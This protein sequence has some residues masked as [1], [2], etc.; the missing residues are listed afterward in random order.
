ME[1]RKDPVT[2]SWMLVGDDEGAFWQEPA[3]PCEW[4]S[5][6]ALSSGRPI[7]VSPGGEVKVYPHPHPL[8]RIEGTESS[9]AEGL[10]D[11]MRTVGAHEVVLESA[12]H[13]RQVSLA[14]DREAAEVLSTFAARIIDLKKD[15]RFRYVTVVKNRGRLA[16]EEFSHA[17]SQITATPFIPRRLVYELRAARAHFQAKERCVFCDIVQQEEA[18]GTRVVE[19]TANYLALCPFA[20]RVPYELWILPRYHAASYEQ[21]IAGRSGDVQELAG[22]VRRALARVQHVAEAYHTVLH[23]SP[24]TSTQR[25]V[26]VQWGTLPDDYHWHI[27]ILPIAE[28][29]TRSYSI[30]EVYYSA[31]SP[32]RAAAALRRV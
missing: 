22:V 19:A 23:T 11:R 29:R 2:Q 10:Y 18:I 14:T 28:K 17:H 15:Q 13:E 20:S 5:G 24:N 8:Y 3:G 31:V 27:E 9:T 6:G 1:L 32:E 21:D 12:T 7:Y 25:G 16:G 4:C 30:K 26:K